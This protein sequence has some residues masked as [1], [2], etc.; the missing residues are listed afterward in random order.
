MNSI[1][2]EST[3]EYLKKIVE[4]NELQETESV[5]IVE[6]LISPYINLDIREESGQKNISLELLP[7]RGIFYP[8]DLVITATS[9]KV[10]E[11]RHFSSIDEDDNIDISDKINFVINAGIKTQS[12]TGFSPKCL[13]EIDRFYLLFLIRDLTFIDYPSN[14][15]ID[16]TCVEC[17]EKDSVDLRLNRLGVIK[18]GV[19]DHY[20]EKYTSESRSIKLETEK[21]SIDLYFPSIHNLEIARKMIKDEEIPVKD[22][23]KFMLCF[24]VPPQTKLSK[25]DF[26]SFE[27]EIDEWTPVKYALVKDFIEKVNSSYLLS[28]FY[29]CSSCGAGVTAP[30][31]FQQGF[32]RLFIPNFS[33]SIR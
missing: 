14:L 4:Q 10:K 22:Q 12:S 29:K 8:S 3:E 23:D 31:R 5:K 26:D 11:I 2:N 1:F 6:K 17:G 24:T 33:D 19:I 32:K 20:M 16:S 13:L 21:E 18:E 7:S 27:K 15:Y 9:L 28:L 30:I 25:Q